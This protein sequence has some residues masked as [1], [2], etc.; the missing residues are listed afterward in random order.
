MNLGKGLTFWRVDLTNVSP[1]G[2]LVTHS[3]GR[4]S[5]RTSSG[6]TWYKIANVRD[7]NCHQVYQLQYLKKMV[8]LSKYYQSTVAEI[9]CHHDRWIQR[10]EIQ[11]GNW[12]F[13]ESCISLQNLNHKA[14]DIILNFLCKLINYQENMKLK[15]DLT[16]IVT[17][18]QILKQCF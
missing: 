1:D 14:S 7:E 5:L 12:L 13:I 2:V 3:G 8:Y 18:F 10:C 17:H 11:R 4:L 9:I 16:F 6:V 15:W